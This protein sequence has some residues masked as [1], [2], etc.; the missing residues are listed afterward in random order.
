MHTICRLLV[1]AVVACAACAFAG[2]ETNVATVLVLGDSISVMSADDYVMQWER[3][4]VHLPV[5]NAVFGAGVCSGTGGAD[6]AY[7]QSRVPNVLSS[8]SPSTVVVELGTNDGACADE[9]GRHI[10]QFMAL[11]PTDKLVL[12]VNVGDRVPEAPVLNAAI[13]EAQKRFH[14]LRVADYH[15]HFAD[16][17]EW[18]PAAP[19]VHLNAAGQAELAV[20]LLGQVNATG[21]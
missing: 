1:A 19:N 16:H 6:D 20:W 13:D 5:V 18:F 7:W 10:N 3:D 4:D 21:T 8:V 17:P 9:Y 12:W 15:T 11:L 2:C 14:N